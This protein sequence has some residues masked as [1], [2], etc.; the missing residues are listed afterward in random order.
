MRVFKLCFL[1]SVAAAV[2]TY[3]LPLPYDE[4]LV[5][6]DSDSTCGNG[7]CRHGICMCDVQF[8]S[9]PTHNHTC[10][11][12]RYRRQSA[13][14]AQI[15]G[16]CVALGPGLLGWVYPQ[17]LHW[18]FMV[19][20]LVSGVMLS[21]Y[22]KALALHRDDLLPSSERED[23]TAGCMIGSMVAFCVAL[24]STLVCYILY[25]VWIGSSQCVDK[26]GVQC[27]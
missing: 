25:A 15:F 24:I 23:R 6:C 17:L 12:A 4:P 19:C 2:P 14:I 11:Y 20:M 27:Y 3:F 26:N 18:G 21:K 8:S 1:C 16:G 7:W 10:A 22:S 5:P 13:L 9:Y